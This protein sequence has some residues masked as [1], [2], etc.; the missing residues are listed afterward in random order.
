M[1]AIKNVLLSNWYST[2]APRLTPKFITQHSQDWQLF[3]EMNYTYMQENWPQKYSNVTQNTFI[4]DYSKN[5]IQR[6][7]EG[8]RA[9]FLYFQ[10]IDPI[11][12]SNVYL[13]G[14]KKE[15]LNIAEFYVVPKKRKQ[16]FGH[17]MLGHLIEWGKE[18]GAQELRIEV[19]KD[20][21]NA[22]LFW[23]TFGFVLDSSGLRNLYIYKLL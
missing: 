8:N 17:E 19:D 15:V 10:A 11:G 18:K 9:L 21:V 20:L 4:S 14:E 22:N 5:L 2:M 1:F 7:E 23:S 12:F 13:S 16:K 3:L 6:I